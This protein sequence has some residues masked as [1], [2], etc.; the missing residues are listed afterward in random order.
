MVGPE[1][2]VVNF[3][4][5]DVSEELIRGQQERAR[6]DLDAYIVSFVRDHRGCGS[7]TLATAFGVFGVL[8][9][10]HVAHNLFSREGRLVGLVITKEAAAFSLEKEDVEVIDLAW[11]G[12]YSE[13]GPD[14]AFVRILNPELLGTV[15]GKKSFVPLEQPF[16]DGYERAFHPKLNPTPWVVA[17]APACLEEHVG[18][19]GK[20]GHILKVAHFAGDVDFVSASDVGGFDLLQFRSVIGEGGYPQDYEGVSGG[21]LWF[22][23]FEYVPEQGLQ[24]MRSMPPRLAGVIFYRFYGDGIQELVAHGPRSVYGLALQGLR[25]RFGG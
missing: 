8:T 13:E 12:R 3:D 20:P 4:L 23:P 11:S 18:D 15:K 5:R 19:I 24:S 7:G 17:G 1:S 21:G 9:A 6:G 2:E 14:L 16:I 22:C 25:E 10:H